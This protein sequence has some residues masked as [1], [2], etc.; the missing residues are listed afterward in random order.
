MIISL[1]IF[2]TGEMSHWAESKQQQRQQLQARRQQ[3]PLQQRDKQLNQVTANNCSIKIFGQ[4]YTC[5]RSC[6]DKLNCSD[7][8]RSETQD[9]S[10]CSKTDSGK[11]SRL[12]DKVFDIILISYFGSPDRGLHSASNIARRRS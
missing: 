5:C 7:M 12:K 6:D 4:K 11:S 3:E 10:L 9:S 1:H 2:V 8:M